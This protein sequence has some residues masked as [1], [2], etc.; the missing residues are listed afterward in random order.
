MNLIK[1]QGNE[2]KDAHELRRMAEQFFIE[3]VSYGFGIYD[4]YYVELC[5]LYSQFWERS[6]HK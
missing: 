2:H 4:L 6:Y 1:F 5:S 3:Y